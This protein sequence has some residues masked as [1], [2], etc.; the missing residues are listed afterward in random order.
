MKSEKRKV[1]TWRINLFIFII[2][3]LGTMFGILISDFSVPS[4]EG[5]LFNQADVLESN[6]YVNVNATYSNATASN[7]TSS[8]ATSSNATSSN[9]APDAIFVQYIEINTPTIKAG[10]KM[11]I[12]FATVG[13][14]LNGATFTFVN[15]E[16]GLNFAAQLEYEDDGRMYLDI[17]EEVVAGTYDL[18]EILLIGTSNSGGT[19]SVS[20]KEFAGHDFNISLVVE[21]DETKKDI[22]L[23][24][25]SFEKSEVDIGDELYFTIDT[26]V[27][28]LS[29]KFVFKNVETA[30][31]ITTYMKEKDNKKYLTFA[32]NVRGGNYEI[33]SL[34]LTSDNT[35]TIYSKN[36]NGNVKQFDFNTTITLNEVDLTNLEYNNE[37]I[38]AEVIEEIKNS[39]TAKTITINADTKAIVSFDVF[40]AVKGTKKELIINYRN[41][42]YIFDCSKITMAKDVD[43][44][45]KV[46]SMKNTT[47][48]T[49]VKSFVEDGIIVTFADNGTLP[50]KAKIRIKQ[51]SELKEV[52][53]NNSVYVY[54]FDEI[55]RMFEKVD[56]NVKAKD[57]YYE[58]EITHNSRY[59]LTTAPIDE[60]MIQ[61]SEDEVVNFVM[62]DKVYLILIIL[63]LVLVIV[64]LVILVV[65][66][67][68][69]G[70][71][72]KQEK[73]EENNKVEE[74]V[75][76]TSTEE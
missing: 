41:N 8:N 23:N 35:T 54:Y 45:M 69:K 63:A 39:K 19:F 57:S 14:C 61:K 36:G 75:T 3:A 24:S 15:D 53:G 2:F 34:T 27:E 6:S 65:Y 55:N 67:R 73:K 66:N 68:A 47:K 72:N 74:K 28:L 42:Q 21:K 13:N 52:L 1:F 11:Y 31:T 48:D 49:D 17:P 9:S 29:A 71:K 20:Y 76:D 50:G 12:N 38:N 58:F 30:E 46:Y 51:T 4:L 44:S 22:V 40:D 7:A 64:I 62:S 5:Y 60:N 25:I 37:D 56:K 26:D 59:V 10:E 43:V 18:K 32:T 16:M 33:E 70:K